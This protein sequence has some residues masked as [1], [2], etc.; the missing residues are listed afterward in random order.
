MLEP[1]IQNAICEYLEMRGHF[2]WRQNTTAVFD[3]AKKRYRSLPKY[4]VA[5]VSDIILIQ[6]GKAYFLEVKRQKPKTYQSD[7]QKEFEAKAKKA[8]AVYEVVRSVK[9]VQKL[10]L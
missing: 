6:E 5:G 1:E 10:G 2:F 7:K 4:A 9:D 8:G 3:P